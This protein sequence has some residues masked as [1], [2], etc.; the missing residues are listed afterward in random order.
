[1]TEY[2]LIVGLIAIATIGII[3]LFGDNVRRLFAM[4]ADALAGNGSV[5]QANTANAV[6]NMSLNRKTLRDFAESHVPY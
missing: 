3:T 4:S 2:I 6:A 1:M 5:M